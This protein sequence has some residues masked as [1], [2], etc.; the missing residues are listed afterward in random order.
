VTSTYDGTPIA[1]LA[2]AA[3]DAATLAL[4]I[5]SPPQRADVI[6]NELQQSSKAAD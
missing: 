1:P 2:L 6:G 3:I 5:A 4:G